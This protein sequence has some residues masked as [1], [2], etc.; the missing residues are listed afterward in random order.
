MS[1]PR[2]GLHEP[3]SWMVGFR[4]WSRL[5]SSSY[6]VLFLPLQHCSQ[7]SSN[8]NSHC[9]YARRETV[10]DKNTERWQF[11]Q[12]C[13]LKRTAMVEQSCV[14]WNSRRKWYMYEKHDRTVTLVGK[15]R[16][17]CGSQN[18]QHNYARGV[19]VVDRNGQSCNGQNLYWK[20]ARAATIV[21]RIVRAVTVLRQVC[22]GCNGS[23]Y[24]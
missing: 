7:D 23:G 3:R 19:R 20:H 21:G 6:L 4:R 22:Q 17:S 1:H 18:L 8:Q 12:L 11:L 10:V 24:K 2:L 13:Q 16:Q 14:S 5:L 15:N 9:K